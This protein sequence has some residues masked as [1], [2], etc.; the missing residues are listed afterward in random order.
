LKH[1]LSGLAANMGSP[2]ANSADKIARDAPA[3]PTHDPVLSRPAAL[4][5]PLFAL[6]FATGGFPIRSHK[7]L[8]MIMK[9]ET[10][11]V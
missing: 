10:P 6:G 5:D 1:L 8:R 2:C 11:I 9:P 7:A 4:L 3:E